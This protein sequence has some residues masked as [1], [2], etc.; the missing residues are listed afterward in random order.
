MAI[1]SQPDIELP[2]LL[3]LERAGGR[4]QKG[5]L[6]SRIALHFPD[7]TQ[8]DLRLIRESTGV[9]LWKNTVDWARNA[10]H[11]KGHLNGGESGIWEITELGRKRLRGDFSGFGLSDKE[12]E[13]LIKSSDTLPYRLG[14]KWKPRELR[15]RHV[16]GFEPE[17]SRE[18]E[19]QPEERG[20]ESKET[21]DFPSRVLERLCSL[22]PAQFEQLVGK[23]LEAK[24]L[25]DIKITGRPGDRGI[26]GEAKVPFLD[27]QIAFQAKRYEPA[28]NISYQDVA[29]FKGSLSIRGLSRGVFITTSSFTPG[30]REAAEQGEPKIVLVDGNA[31]VA[32]LIEYNVG[33]V[34]VPVIEMKID[35]NFFGSL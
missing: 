7:M 27:I 28:N 30:A 5:G 9:N 33:V 6:Y 13:D 32:T 2:L 17:R 1:P 23:V 16:K 26:D 4:V 21:M 19:Q 29:A 22:R 25:A 34:K 35:D 20:V 31:L 3:E 8:E 14:E 11:T 24:G 15:P 18:P 12:V 10:L